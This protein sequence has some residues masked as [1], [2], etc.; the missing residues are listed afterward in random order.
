LPASPASRLQL[1]QQKKACGH[2]KNDITFV[3]P[4]LMLNAKKERAL[5][6]ATNTKQTPLCGDC[7]LPF[8]KKVGV[9]YSIILIE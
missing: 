1:N 2:A 5:I 6:K 7:C 4:F 8:L 9:L 3:F